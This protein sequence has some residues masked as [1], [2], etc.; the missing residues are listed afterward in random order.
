MFS[1]KHDGDNLFVVI[2]LQCLQLC[3]RCFDCHPDLKYTLDSGLPLRLIHTHLRKTQQQQLRQKV[4]EDERRHAEQLNTLFN[5]N[6]EEATRLRYQL[7]LDTQD[8]NQARLMLD[9]TRTQACT[10][11]QEMASQRDRMHK[12]T[13][14]S[15][16]QLAQA[17]L[18]NLRQELYASQAQATQLTIE[19]SGSRSQI[20]DLIVQLNWQSTHTSCLRRANRR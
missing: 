12:M 6:A 15:A 17:D 19:L 9:K 3:P 10:P 1:V 20:F 8:G 16:A 2:G 11:L 7:A 18:E 14:Q 4:E 5:R 13:H